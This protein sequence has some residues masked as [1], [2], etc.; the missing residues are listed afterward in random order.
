MQL[1]NWKGWSQH[2]PL[3]R[4]H[5]R[6]G[7]GGE[8]IYLEIPVYVRPSKGKQ[9]PPPSNPFV[10]VSM[11]AACGLFI[12]SCQ[13]DFTTLLPS[14]YFP[15]HYSITELELMHLRTYTALVDI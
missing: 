2:P 13:Q 3:P 4:S 11:G 10:S 5:L 9:L 14:L 15:S 12:I 1:S 6:V 7:S 8:G